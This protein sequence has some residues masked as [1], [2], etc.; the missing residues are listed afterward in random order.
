MPSFFIL[1]HKVTTCIPSSLAALFAM[2]FMLGKVAGYPRQF[3]LTDNFKFG[4]HY[5]AHLHV[6]LDVQVI[7]QPFGFAVVKR[8]M[9]SI[10]ERTKYFF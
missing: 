9:S 3:L 7:P 1:R 5:P 10:A 2:A 6:Q 8:S 4:T